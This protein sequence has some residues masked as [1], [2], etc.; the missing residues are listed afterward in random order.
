MKALRMWVL[1]MGVGGAGEGKGNLRVVLGEREQ[2]TTHL[3]LTDHGH[4][5][6]G[7]I[8]RHGSCDNLATAATCSSTACG[9]ERIRRV[10][11]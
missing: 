10:S 11:E 4:Y 6:A 9:V 2:H 1:V 7:L 3:Q 5:G 8:S